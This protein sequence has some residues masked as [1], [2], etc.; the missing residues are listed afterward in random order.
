VG[1][2]NGADIRIGY[3]DHGSGQPGGAHPRLPLNAHSWER[4]ERVLL[5]P[6][7]GSSPTTGGACGIE[8]K[9]ARAAPTEEIVRVFERQHGTARA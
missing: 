2:E 3:E 6:G 9:T 4:Q 5:Q 8:T 7:T 1:A